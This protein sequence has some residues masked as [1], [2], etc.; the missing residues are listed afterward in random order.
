M[1]P[2]VNGRLGTVAHAAQ[3]IGIPRASRW[4]PAL[5]RNPRTV[6]AGGSDYQGLANN[7]SAFNF[8]SS[9][10]TPATSPT[11]RMCSPRPLHRN[12]SRGRMGTTRRRA[13]ARF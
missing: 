7:G 12:A 4:V 1:T 6:L 11:V 9:R 13:P 8:S 10:R 3:A 5:H 2:G